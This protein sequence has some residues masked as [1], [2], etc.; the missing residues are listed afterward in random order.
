MS[1]LANHIQRRNACTANVRGMY[2]SLT[3]STLG[4]DKS[5]TCNLDIHALDPLYNITHLWIK[6]HFLRPKKNDNS[7]NCLI[8]HI[9][10]SIINLQ[11]EKLKEKGALT[12]IY[13]NVYWG[14][15]QTLFSNREMWLSSVCGYN[16]TTW[17][18]SEHWKYLSQ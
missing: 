8:I 11:I 5:F 9:H 4:I 6:I 17:I 18:L 10:L 7:R 3:I 15:A 14:I 13:I 12:G 2:R 16:S 1:C